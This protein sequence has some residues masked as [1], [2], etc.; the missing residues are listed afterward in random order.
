MH[1]DCKHVRWLQGVSIADE[2]QAWRYVEVLT[3]VEKAVG[4]GKERLG[5]CDPQAIVLRA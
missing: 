2:L 4:A 1:V 5:I 3:A